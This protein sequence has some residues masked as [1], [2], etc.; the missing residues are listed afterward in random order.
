MTEGG[1]NLA[2]RRLRDLRSGQEK[3]TRQH[4]RVERRL[5]GTHEGMTTELG[6]AAHS[7]VVTKQ[8]GQRF[9]EVTDQL[10]ALRRRVSD[11]ESKI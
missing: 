6:M 7:N 11:L 2:P 10:K 8:L 3:Q 9:D 5:D 1:D 4:I